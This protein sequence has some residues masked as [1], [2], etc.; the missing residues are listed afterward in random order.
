MQ[1]RIGFVIAA[2]TSAVRLALVHPWL[3]LLLLQVRYVGLSNETP[4]GLCKAL[5]LAGE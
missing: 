4:W 5:A 3:L 2:L 1:G